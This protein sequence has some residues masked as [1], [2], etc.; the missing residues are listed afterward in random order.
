MLSMNVSHGLSSQRHPALPPAS[1]G[2]KMKKKL[3]WPSTQHNI[4]CKQEVWCEPVERRHC[5]ADGA[6]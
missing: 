6:S 2:A 3:A 4:R 1:T 5:D